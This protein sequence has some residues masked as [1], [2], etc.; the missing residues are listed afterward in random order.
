[1]ANEE[2]RSDAGKEVTTCRAHGE[3][4]AR[5][6]GCEGNEGCEKGVEDGVVHYASLG[7]VDVSSTLNQG[8]LGRTLTR[9]H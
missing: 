5:E 4:P 6:V 7:F 2:G 3:F 8:L 9:G 1:M